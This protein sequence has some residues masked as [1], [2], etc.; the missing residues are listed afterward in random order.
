M[1]G[2]VRAV[3][4][5]SPVVLFRT[6]LNT[7]VLR[8]VLPYR[9]LRYCCTSSSFHGTVVILK[10]SQYRNEVLSFLSCLYYHGTVGNFDMVG[11]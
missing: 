8:T 2:K 6:V 3:I 9:S 1:K 10:N 5:E 4:V 7:V 11:M